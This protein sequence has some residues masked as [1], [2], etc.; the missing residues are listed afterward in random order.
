MTLIPKIRKP[1][2]PSD[3]RSISLYNVTMKLV[4]KCTT[5]RLKNILHDIIDHVQ[6]TFIPGRLLKDNA[7]LVLECFYFLKTHR[8]GKKRYFTLKLDV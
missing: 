4:T 3:F 8:N 7:I 6:N 5:N 1:K 2:V